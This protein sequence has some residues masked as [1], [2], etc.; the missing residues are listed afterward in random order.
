MDLYIRDWKPT[1]K[2]P[3][4]RVSKWLLYNGNAAN[5]FQLYHGENKLI[6]NEFRFVLEQYT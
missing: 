2:Y 1:S 5:F 3:K 4:F 6:F